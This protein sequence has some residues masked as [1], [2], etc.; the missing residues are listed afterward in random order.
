[1]AGLLALIAFFRGTVAI[2]TAMTTSEATQKI[3]AP[4]K[5]DVTSTSVKK[6]RQQL[7]GLTAENPEGFGYFYET[8]PGY[9]NSGG[10]NF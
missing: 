2:Q 8:L 6:Y 5:C 4:W 10:A 1:M 7:K 3:V 9:I